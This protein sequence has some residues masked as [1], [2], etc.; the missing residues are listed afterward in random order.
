MHY[1]TLIRWITVQWIGEPVLRHENITK[2]ETRTFSRIRVIKDA[3]FTLTHVLSANILLFP[4]I[5]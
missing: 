2:K 4:M 1:V 5:E 3:L